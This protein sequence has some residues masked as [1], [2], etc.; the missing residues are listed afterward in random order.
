M[1]LFP[2]KPGPSKSH[3]VRQ[4]AAAHKYLD[5]LIAGRRVNQRL[6]DWALRMTGDLA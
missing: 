1:T 3:E 5:R 2:R 4:R 6:V